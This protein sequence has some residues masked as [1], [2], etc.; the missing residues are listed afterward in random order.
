MCHRAAR[1]ILP[2][3]IA[4]SDAWTERHEGLTA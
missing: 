1:R 2:P 4:F 3:R